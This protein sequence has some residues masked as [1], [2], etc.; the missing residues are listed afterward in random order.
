[1]DYTERKNVWRQKGGPPGA[2][3]FS[4]HR[5]VVVAPARDDAAASA[6]ERGRP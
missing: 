3:N 5:T 2:V 6:T 1:V 4:R